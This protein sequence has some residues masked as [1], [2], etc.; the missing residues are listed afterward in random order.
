MHFYVRALEDTFSSNARDVDACGNSK[1]EEQKREN[2]K[3]EAVGIVR[4]LLYLW[5]KSVI[6]LEGC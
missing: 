5:E 2:K 4:V 1:E 3:E 6:L